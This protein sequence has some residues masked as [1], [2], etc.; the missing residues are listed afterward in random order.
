MRRGSELGVVRRG[1][2]LGVVFRRSVKEECSR[3]VFWEG[4]QGYC[5]GVLFSEKG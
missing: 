5:S 3:G 4:V 1:N 2:E